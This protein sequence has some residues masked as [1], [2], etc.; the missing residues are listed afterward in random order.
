M[1]YT[2]RHI[3]RIFQPSPAVSKFRIYVFIRSIYGNIRRIFVYSP[4]SCRILLGN[5]KPQFDGL[6]KPAIVKEVTDGVE[7]LV[8]KLKCMKGGG[9]VES[10][11]E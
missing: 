6:R 4:Y 7:G 8:C 10:C 1:Y 5:S 3:R 2:V 9:G 11:W